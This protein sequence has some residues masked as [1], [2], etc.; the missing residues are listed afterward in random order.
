[1]THNISFRKTRIAPTPSGYLHVGNILSFVITSKIAAKENVGILLRIDD[2]YWEKPD[3]RYVQDIF[4]TLNFLEIPWS[5]GPRNIQ[6]YENE[7]SQQHR[8][9]NYKNTLQ[10]LK[11]NGH[12]YACT[13]SRAKVLGGNNQGA[14]AGT[15]RHKNIP[16]ESDKVCWR[17]RTD[18]IIDLT[19]RNYG[20]TVFKSRLPENMHDF[21]VRRKDG[22]PAYQLVSVLDDLYFGVDLVVRGED[23]LASTL[24]QQYLSY[25]L[26]F[27][28]F[29]DI[30]FYHHPLLIGNDGLKLSKSFGSTSIHYLRQQGVTP[31]AI[32]TSIAEL[33]HINATPKNWQDLAELID[34]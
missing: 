23:L 20:G 9:A 16:L 1:M 17:L 13:C 34:L 6:E 26:G 22:L 30:R 27:D 33:L 18:D 32:F 10:Q 29:R 8:I 12:L 14:Y 2:L 21:I 5:A 11:E 24:A 25:K 19:V 4:D 3:K 15:C 28:N 31:A 7:Y